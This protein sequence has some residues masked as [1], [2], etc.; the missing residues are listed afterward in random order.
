[1]AEVS[2]L[3][4]KLSSYAEKSST[5]HS[6]VVIADQQAGFSVTADLAQDGVLPS[7]S[8]AEKMAEVFARAVNVLERPVLGEDLRKQKDK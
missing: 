7:A 1:M 4:Q 8:G 6:P 2:L 5:A 3:N